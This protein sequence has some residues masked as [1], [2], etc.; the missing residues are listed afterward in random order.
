MIGFSSPPTSQATRA[1]RVPIDRARSLV[2][3]RAELD[4]AEVFRAFAEAEAD[5]DAAQGYVR[6]A[7]RESEHARRWAIRFYEANGRMPTREPS[8]LG[9]L[10]AATARRFGPRPVE[11]VTRHLRRLHHRLATRD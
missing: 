10:L 4:S 6:M 5:F 2:L 7:D 3:S 8:W 11:P 9:R 1:P